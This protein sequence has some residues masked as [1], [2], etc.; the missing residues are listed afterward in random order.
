MPSRYLYVTVAFTAIAAGFHPVGGQSPSVA[1]GYYR[2]ATESDAAVAFR[3]GV[4][5]GIAEAS[6]AADLL[7]GSVTL[8]DLR[9]VDQRAVP[10]ATATIAGISAIIVF[11]PDSGSLTHLVD[12]AVRERI[13]VIVAGP[14]LA[15]RCSGYIF[16][17][18]VPPVAATDSVRAELALWHPSLERF[19]AAQLSQRY[20]E[21]YGR[22]MESSA[23]SGWMAIKIIWES[24]LRGGTDRAAFRDAVEHGSFDG[25]KGRAL[26]FGADHYLIQPLVRVVSGGDHRVS[27]V[28]WPGSVP[29]TPCT[30]DHP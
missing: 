10:P 30:S 25:H 22:D 23:W 14:S 27:E 2:P 16:R 24:A 9:G 13:P 18:D 12:L 17:I 21:R 5:M 28:P 6:R 19:G 3:R 8:I 1:I 4:D 29:T 20:R 11:A 7:R 26:R 15:T